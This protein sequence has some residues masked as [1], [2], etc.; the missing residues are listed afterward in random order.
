MPVRRA[1]KASHFVNFYQADSTKQK[2]VLGKSG[3]G[4]Q[5]TL[6]LCS[7]IGTELSAAA[8][9]YYF[10]C[11]NDNCAIIENFKQMEKFKKNL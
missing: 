6:V 3:L 2:P 8:G 1:W 4:V 5:F 11:D 7:I 10:R 9:E